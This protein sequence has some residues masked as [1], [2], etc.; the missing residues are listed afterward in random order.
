MHQ[1]CK[2]N[3]SICRKYE[4]YFFRRFKCR[5]EGIGIFVKGTSANTGTNAGTI[6]LVSGKTG[7][8]GM[9]TKTAGIEIQ[10]L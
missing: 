3:S 1:L 2:R 7:A 10:E 8:V 6:D 4:Y 5:T 9:Y